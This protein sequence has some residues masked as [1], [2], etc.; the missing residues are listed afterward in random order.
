M[1]KI[2]TLAPFGSNRRRL[3][4]LHTTLILKA[5]QYPLS[6]ASAMPHS[7]VLLV[8]V[9]VDVTEDVVVVAIAVVEL[10]VLHMHHH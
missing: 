4:L 5:T 8:V 9:V 10:V 3:C 2:L 7:V 1:E 6:E